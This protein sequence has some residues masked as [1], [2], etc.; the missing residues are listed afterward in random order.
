M[1]YAE[2]LNPNSIWYKKRHEVNQ[3]SNITKEQKMDNLT[4]KRISM[5][6]K[7]IKFFGKMLGNN[8]GEVAIPFIDS[9]AEEQRPAV[10]TFITNTGA[11]SED[12]AGYKTYDEFLSG[13]KPKSQG[14]WTT[15]LDPE[16]KALIGIKGWKTPGDAIKSY[17]E[18]EKLVGHEKIAMPK[19]D[20][21]GNYEP[22]EFERVMTQLGLPKD[23]K[24]YKPSANFK[25]P[26]GIEINPQLE[27]EFKAR[28]KA[29]GLLPKQYAFMMDE[30]SGMLTRGTQAHKEAQ[31]KNFNE[32][33]LNL[34]VKWGSAY[35]EKSRLA[36]KVLQTFGDQTKIAD[37]V[38]KY[39]NNP[40][41]IE[42]LANIGENLS[43]ESLTKVGMAGVSMS[44]EEARI[45]IMKVRE[46]R[47]KELMDA[48][49]PQH[50]YWV[51]KLDELYRFAAKQ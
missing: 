50:K 12:L 51:D 44:P 37:I 42:V 45:Q 22:G 8:R 36:N 40:E 20:V 41:I 13:Y 49:N 17:S 4:P 27:T 46:E 14:D 25:L 11:T 2:K 31:E 1:G 23:P 34:R 9:V 47:N 19:K 6:Q 43:E 39:G 48:G 5:A 24:E 3:P 29:A 26:E 32:S 15:S 28:A 10:N 35:D 16:H 7:A 18:I 38:K 30:L 33:V 21:Q